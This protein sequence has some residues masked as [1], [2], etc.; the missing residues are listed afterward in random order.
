MSLEVYKTLSK[1][2][3]PQNDKGAMKSDIYLSNTLEKLDTEQYLM[4]SIQVNP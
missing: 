1:K 4:S 2:F 3:K